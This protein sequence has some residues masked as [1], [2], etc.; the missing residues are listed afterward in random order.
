MLELR[1]KAD[2]TLLNAAIAAAEGIDLSSY[3]AQSV[4]QFNAALAQ[5]KAIAAD[6][7]LT[8]KE[9][10]AAVDEAAEQLRKA[11]QGLK[12]ADGTSANL[13]IDG[14][15]TLVKT[16]SAKTGDTV[17]LAAAAVLLLAGAA[18]I[19]KKRIR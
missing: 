3:S 19:L 11:V 15:G 6:E 8:A 14:D 4:E 16:N 10:Q 5:A 1:F 12:N 9:D 17:P 2:K 7:T 13:S 18:F